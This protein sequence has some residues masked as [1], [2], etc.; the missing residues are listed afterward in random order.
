MGIAMI[1]SNILFFAAHTTKQIAF[2][3]FVC[4]FPV[5]FFYFFDCSSISKLVAYNMIAYFVLISIWNC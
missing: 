2:C 4:E 3:V 1:A 5:F